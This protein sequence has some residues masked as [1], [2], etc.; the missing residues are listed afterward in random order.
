MRLRDAHHAP[1]LRLTEIPE[2]AKRDDASLSPV[3]RAH[4]RVDHRT[5]DPL[6]VDGSATP[7][8]S[9]VLLLDQGHMGSD[10]RGEDAILL[11]APRDPHHGAAVSE[12]PSNLTLDAARNIRPELGDALRVTA[13]D[14]PDQPDRADL[15]QILE[16]LPAAG[17]APGD[18]PHQ[19]EM[20]L[21]QL[22]PRGWAAQ[23]A[24]T[25]PSCFVN[26]DGHTVAA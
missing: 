16:A 21:D 17:E 10:Q 7:E 6:L 8:R 26:V 9:R 19:W 14:G 20:S 24:R 23:I 3:E 15:N 18:P 25:I 12:M 22:A 1:D 4:G 13:I 2:I 11:D 5:R